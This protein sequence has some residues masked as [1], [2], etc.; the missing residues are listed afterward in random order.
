MLGGRHRRE[1][2]SIDRDTILAASSGLG[3]EPHSSPNLRCVTVREGE[4]AGQMAGL[5]FSPGVVAMRHR[6]DWSNPFHSPNC[7][8]G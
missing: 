7:L 1:M 3:I 5:H 6:R 4:G 8:H 2:H